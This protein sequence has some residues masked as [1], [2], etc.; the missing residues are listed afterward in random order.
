M[1]YKILRECTN[2]ELDMGDDEDCRSLGVT[3]MGVEVVVSECP[4]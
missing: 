3:W 4:L 2:N 1:S